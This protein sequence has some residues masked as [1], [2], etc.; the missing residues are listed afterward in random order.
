MGRYTSVQ[1]YA[2]NN[3]SVRAISY[4]QATGS[5]EPKQGSVKT[6]KVSNPYGSTAGAGSGDFHVYRHARAREMERWKRIEEEEAEKELERQFQLELAACKT[7]G[8]RKTARNRRKRQREKQAKLR[9][10][11]LQ[12]AG[13]DISQQLATT[14]NGEDEA[15]EFSYTP[16]EQQKQQHKEN[17]EETKE[18]EEN[19]LKDGEGQ[20]EQDNSPKSTLEIPN[21]GSFLEMMKKR[22][23]EEALTESSCRVGDDFTCGKDEEYRMQPPAKKQI[24]TCKIHDI[25]E[26]EAI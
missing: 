18:L 7:E 10:K 12:A 16:V 22:L 14:G 5:A 21:D 1:A 11:N 15:E 6:E 26:D 24:I 19:C 3:S 23:A 4:E 13:I 9:K 25:D 20:Q 8:E 2:D 17:Q